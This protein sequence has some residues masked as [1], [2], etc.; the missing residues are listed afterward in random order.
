M[1]LEEADYGITDMALGRNAAQAGDEN[2]LV[3]FFLH[4]KRDHDKSEEEGRPMFKEV[5]YIEIITPGNKDNIISRPASEIDRKRFPRHYAAYKARTSQV[6][7]E[8]TPLEEWP[9]ITRSLVEELR[10]ANILTV[11][12]LIAVSD[13]DAQKFRGFHAIKDKARKFLETAKGQNSEL[14]AL[15]AQNADLLAR[16]ERLEARGITTAD[17][18]STAAD[19]VVDAEFEKVEPTTPRRRAR[20]AVT[21]E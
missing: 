15:K 5:E 18:Q 10:F 12:Q 21:Q 13:A 14:D 4:P 1:G 19:D 17:S 3:R 9:G 6:V 2:L 7:V 20:T 8:G 11:E 16:L